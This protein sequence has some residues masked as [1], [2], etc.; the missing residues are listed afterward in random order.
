VPRSHYNN[1][2]SEN[3]SVWI[4]LQLLFENFSLIKTMHSVI[5][6][7]LYNSKIPWLVLQK[8]KEVQPTMGFLC[9]FS[10]VMHR[11]FIRMFHY[12]NL[13]FSVWLCGFSIEKLN[14]FS[15]KS[16]WKAQFWRP[17]HAWERNITINHK[18]NVRAKTGTIW[19]KIGP[20]E[21]FLW[22]VHRFPNLFGH[23]I[24]WG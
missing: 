12:F 24:F 14:N 10:N 23:E 5:V 20:S 4:V 11:V 15:E 16:Q 1:V 13:A 9:L 22:L 7:L 6:V 21:A 17:I 18:Y 3:T 8:R 2:C 19:L